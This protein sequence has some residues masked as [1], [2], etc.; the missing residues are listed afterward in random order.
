MSSGPPDAF[1]Y[2]PIPIGRV[3]KRWLDIRDKISLPEDM[4]PDIAGIRTVDVM[5]NRKIMYQADATDEWTTPKETL[6]RGY[7]DCEDIALVKRAILLSTGYK[8]PDIYLFLVKD[9]VARRDHA[10]LIVRGKE[11]WFVL[12]SF[13]SLSLPLRLVIDYVPLLAFSGDKAWF[14]GKRIK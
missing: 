5:V 2:T 1:G 9:L 12:D 3:D 13:N 10:L 11:E 4:C 7:G 8:D 6:E 14:F